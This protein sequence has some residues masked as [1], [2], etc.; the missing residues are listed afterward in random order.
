MGRRRGKFGV[1][2]RS[3]VLHVWGTSAVHW[4]LLPPFLLLLLLQLRL[5]LMVKHV[6]RQRLERQR[7]T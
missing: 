4:L 5:L 7:E 6:Y 2:R 3:A 1:R